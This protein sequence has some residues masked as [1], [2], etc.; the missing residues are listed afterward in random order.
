MKWV[1]DGHDWVSGDYRIEKVWAPG[2]PG[3]AWYPTG[4]GL[5]GPTWLNLANAKA[6]VQ[7]HARLRERK[8][9]RTGR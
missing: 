1:R 8:K 5:D 3:H 2:K 7:H 6:D 9:D 4:P